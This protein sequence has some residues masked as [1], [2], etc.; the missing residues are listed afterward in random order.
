MKNTNEIFNK[1]IEKINNLENEV[2][3]LKNE[4]QKLSNEIK[5]THNCTCINN[6]EKKLDSCTN[7]DDGTNNIVLIGSRNDDFDEIYLINELVRHGQ[8]I[9]IKN[10]ICSYYAK[11]IGLRNTVLFFNRTKNKFEEEN[12]CD[13]IRTVLKPITEEY[14]QYHKKFDFVKWFNSL[15]NPKYDIVCEISRPKVFMVNN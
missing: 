11:V 7:N 13:F 15:F 5:K 3:Q 10:Y 2:K 4:N 6:N 12:Y 9:D 8:L 1:L 14:T